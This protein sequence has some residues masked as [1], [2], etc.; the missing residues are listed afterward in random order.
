MI[1]AE[2]VAAV[3]A[4]GDIDAV[5]GLFRQALTPVVPAGLVQPRWVAGSR[6]RGVFEGY[7]AVRAFA[8]WCEVFEVEAEVEFARPPEVVLFCEVAL[9]GYRVG[10]S[11]W[12]DEHEAGAFFCLNP[13]W[14]VD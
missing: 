9:A 3:A 14:G 6:L 4:D 10:L 11:C 2:Q 12:A 5:D 7:G 8:E 13:G 1:T